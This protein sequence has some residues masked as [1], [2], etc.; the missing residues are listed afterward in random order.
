MCFWVRTPL[1]ILWQCFIKKNKSLGAWAA[2]AGRKG[3]CNSRRWPVVIRKQLLYNPTTAVSHQIVSESRSLKGASNNRNLAALSTIH[4]R[5]NFWTSSWAARPCYSSH[6]HCG[7]LYL[8]SNGNIGCHLSL[9]VFIFEVC[10]G[11]LRKTRHRLVQGALS[12]EDVRESLVEGFF[13]FFY[14]LTQPYITS[15]TPVFN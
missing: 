13:F 10:D 7:R 14:S 9:N 2:T 3:T 6:F 5:K 12:G 1:Q 8:V 11:L 4:V 15:P